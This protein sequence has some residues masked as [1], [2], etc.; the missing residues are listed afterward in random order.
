MNTIC[1]GW[2]CTAIL[3]IPDFWVARITGMSHQCP[4]PP[5]L[6]FLLRIALVIW[7]LLGFFF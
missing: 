1:L 7:E 6:F 5:T 4:A 3:L 2:L